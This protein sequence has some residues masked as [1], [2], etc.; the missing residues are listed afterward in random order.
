MNFSHVPTLRVN[1]SETFEVMVTNFLQFGR[2][3]DGLFF[4]TNQNSVN[5]SEAEIFEL[6]DGKKSQ[7]LVNQC[8][9]LGVS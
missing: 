3:K 5:I 9:T 1:I 8:E 4:C 7:I 6:K 2:A